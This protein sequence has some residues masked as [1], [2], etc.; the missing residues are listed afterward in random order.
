VLIGICKGG[1]K[2][3]PK[4]SKGKYE[5]MESGGGKKEKKKGVHWGGMSE[6]HIFYDGKGGEENE[7][8][9]GVA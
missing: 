1:G 4:L 2:E 8:E 7:G 6:C 9:A 5:A 3:A